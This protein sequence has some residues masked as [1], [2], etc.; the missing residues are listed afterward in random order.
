MTANPHGNTVKVFVFGLKCFTNIKEE[1]LQ[2][3]PSFFITTPKSPKTGD[4]SPT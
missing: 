1:P 2:S 4:F 3:S